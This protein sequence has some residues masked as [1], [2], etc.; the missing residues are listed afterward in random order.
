[1]TRTEWLVRAEPL[2]YLAGSSLDC[3]QLPPVPRAHR[4]AVRRAGSNCGIGT[5]GPRP[6][7]TRTPR[8]R[9]RPSSRGW[10]ATGDPPRFRWWGRAGGVSFLGGALGG[11]DS[12]GLDHRRAV[13]AGLLDGVH[14]S[15]ESGGIDMVRLG[16][17]PWGVSRTRRSSNRCGSISL[18]SARLIASR[19]NPKMDLR[20]RGADDCCVA[21]GVSRGLCGSTR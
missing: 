14:P 15:V 18:V 10:R 7:M 9:R 8:F 1:M 17:R 12:R 20:R 4:S 19:A 11:A 2:D 5:A 21:G 3:A 6:R 13:L 16:E